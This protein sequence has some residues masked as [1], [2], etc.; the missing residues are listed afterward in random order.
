VHDSVL[1]AI[2]ETPLVALDRMGAGLPGRVAVKL[3]YFSPGGSV[4]E[5][6][7]LRIV[8]DAERDGRLQPGG[9]VVEL[10][11]GNMGIGLAVV[12]AVK[13]YR[14][15]AVMS[16]GNSIERRRVL[17]SLGARV[18]LVPQVGGPRP[19]QVSAEDLK[20]VEARTAE[21]VAELGAFH[22]NQFYNPSAVAAHEDTTGPEIWRQTEGRVTHFVT[23][24]GTGGTFVGAA[25]ALKRLNPEV[26]C[27]AGEP[28]SAPFIAG[29]PMTST[30]HRLQ[31]TGYALVP[32]L[33]DPALV[34]GFMTATD[35]EAIETARLLATREGVFGGFSTGANV[36]CALRLAAS[37]PAGSIV[38]TIAP[39]TGMKYL[40]TD[41]FA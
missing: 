7:A 23:A 21:L 32:P 37:V 3:E 30:S 14:M 38:V 20:V 39:D 31:G 33:W 4:K 13:G 10:T 41:L 12:C 16:E 24:V 28:A 9:T 40:S 36:A 29:G 25:R 35:E 17:E 11:S 26:R 34:D 27:Y 1:G 2:G 6:A 15:I 22:A 18:E 5:R 8:E 19:G